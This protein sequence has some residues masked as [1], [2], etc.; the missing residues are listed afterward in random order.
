MICNGAKLS[1]LLPTCRGPEFSGEIIK[2]IRETQRR[3]KINSD[4]MTRIRT[5]VKKVDEAVL[6]GDKKAAQEAFRDA[7]RELS[8]GVS[9]G[10][11]KAEGA[12]RKI[13]RLNDKVRKLVSN[14]TKPE[15]KPAAK[16]ALRK[17]SA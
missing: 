15:V 12:S 6:K 14:T 2:S 13:S 9:K 16:K 8:R 11:L 7:Q 5:F 4:R 3:T 10:L 17:R 1:F